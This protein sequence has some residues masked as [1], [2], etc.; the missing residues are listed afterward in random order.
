LVSGIWHLARDRL[1]SGPKE[2]PK[3]QAARV[4][5]RC[6]LLILK[7][8]QKPSWGKSSLGRGMR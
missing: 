7:H 5:I 2:R 1:P 4:E 3:W 6:N 8:I